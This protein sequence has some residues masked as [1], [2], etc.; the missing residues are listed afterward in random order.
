MSTIPSFIAKEFKIKLYVL[1][2]LHNFWQQKVAK[3][4]P[5]S[6][7]LQNNKIV[8]NSGTPN[9]KSTTLKFKRI[10]AKTSLSPKKGSN[11][12]QVHYSGSSFNVVAVRT[13]NSNDSG[14]DGFTNPAKL[15]LKEER[16]T[17]DRLKCV[18]VR[19]GFM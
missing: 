2:P 4:A 17:A 10:E 1:T 11:M 15:K 13:V 12:T 14:K 3:M 18:N 19:I 16:E 9:G 8:P 6:S 5:S 7:K